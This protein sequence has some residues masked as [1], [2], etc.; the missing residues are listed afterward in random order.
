MPVPDHFD[1]GIAVV[2][3]NGEYIQTFKMGWA[4]SLTQCRSCLALCSL[5]SERI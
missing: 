2:R 1:F 4:G 5:C 3:W